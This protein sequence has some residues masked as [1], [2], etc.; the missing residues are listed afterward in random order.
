MNH[1]QT[2]PLK[3]LGIPASNTSFRTFLG[4]PF[5]GRGEDVIDSYTK[6]QFRQGHRDAER[7]PPICF[8]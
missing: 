1:A 7:D 4:G 6:N 5:A 3:E 2:L 8:R